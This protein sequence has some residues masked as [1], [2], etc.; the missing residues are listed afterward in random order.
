M[1]SFGASADGLVFTAGIVAI[2][3]QG[4]TQHVGDAEA[5]TRHVLDTVG[6]I[7]ESKGCGFEDVVI[8]HI[9]LK[10]MDDYKA[11]NK[12]YGDYF[13]VAPPA[14]FCVAAGLVKDDWLVEIAVV[15]KAS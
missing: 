6:R 7:L 15:A 13:R 11:M 2:D 5:Q 14:R 3:T 10:T 8:A 4:V 9:Y 12:A 1:Y